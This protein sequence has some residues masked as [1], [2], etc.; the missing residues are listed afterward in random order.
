MKKIYVLYAILAVVFLAS[1][2]EDALDIAA[3]GL[4]CHASQ[5]FEWMPPQD[6]VDPNV[7]KTPEARSAYALK[8][9]RDYYLVFTRRYPD[10]VEKLF[11][12]RDVPVTIAELSE[13][14]R[15]PAQCEIDYL[16]S[17][18]GFKWTKK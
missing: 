9:V 10:L 5:L 16:E 12:R 1:S 3:R 15:E 11:G 8:Y 14:S 18:P 2:C 7:L 17:I 6:D 13:Y 4:G